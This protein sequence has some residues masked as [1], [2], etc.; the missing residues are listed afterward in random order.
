MA[1]EQL[2]D[3]RVALQ[4]SP[5]IVDLISGDDAVLARPEYR[6][7]TADT[8][9]MALQ[10]LLNNPI[11]DDQQKGYLLTNSWRINYRDK[12]PTAANFISEKY[13]G[14][15]ALHTYD[16]IRDVFIEF[17]DPTKPYRNLILYPH[18]SWGKAHLNS[19]RVRSYEGG[20]I[21]IGAIKVGDKICTTSGELQTVLQVHPQG[22]VPVYKVTFSDGRTTYATENHLWKAAKTYNMRK[23]S[24]SLKKYTKMDFVEP[25][26]KTVETK[27]IYTS[28]QQNPKARW[29]VPLTKPA[30]HKEIFH[31]IDPY[32]LGALLGDGYLSK[33]AV[34]LVG[35]DYEIH[36][37]CIHNALRENQK[38]AESSTK[39]V[40]FSTL[41]HMGR[42]SGPFHP[43]LTRLKLIDCLSQDKH[44]PEEYLYDSID[45]RIA[46]L[47]GL[48]D[49]DGTVNR[50]GNRGHLQ[51][52]TTSEALKDNFLTLVRG[53]GG[54][55]RVW[56]DNRYLKKNAVAKRPGY[57]VYFTFPENDFP[58]FRL[59]R[60][61]AIVDKDF[62]SFRVQRKPQNLK[63][64]SIAYEGV[65]EATCISVSDPSMLY[66]IDDYIV[67]HNS[68][69]STLINIY[70]GI[71]LSM[72]RNPYKFFGL[73]PA[74]ILSQLLV[75]YS[76]K[77]SS[78]LLLEPLIAILEASPFFE[79]VHTRESM[80]KKDHDYE[81]KTKIDYIYWTTAVPTSAIQ[82]SNGANFKLTSSPQSLLGLSVVSGTMS[83]LGFF[84]DAG[85][86]DEY[87]M[88][89]FN[90]LKSRIDSRMKGNY[91][92]RSILD[93]SPN[94]L[95]SPI[96]DYVVNHSRKDPTNY[97]VDGSVWKWSPDEYDM[98]KTFKVFLGG[99]G[100]PPRILETEAEIS[101]ISPNKM[102][103]VPMQLRQFFMDDLYK[104]LK[105]RAGIPAGSADSLIY[106]YTKLE[107]IFDTRLRNIYTHIHANSDEPA[108]R[109]IWNQ[110]SHLFFKSRAGKMEFWY[111][112]HIPRC[113]SVDQSI[114][115][116]VSC[117][118][119]GHNERIPASDDQMYVID[120]VVPIAPNGAR[121]GLDAIK[122]FIEDLSRQGGMTISHVSFDQF[123]SEASLQYLKSVGF[124][125]EK[126]S[127]DLTTDPYYHLLSLIDTRRI[128][129]G[130]NLYVKNNLKSLKIVKKGKS[131]KPTVDHEDSRPVITVGTEDWNKSLIGFYA[132]D[133][134]DA[135]AAVCDLLRRYHPVAY[136]AWDPSTLDSLVDNTAEKRAAQ[137]K[138]AN[139]MMLKG[140]KV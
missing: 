105:D 41:F 67:T 109:L 75:S 138:M 126:L 27:D 86:D 7:M 136:D 100:Q 85:K 45:N 83:E 113:V 120:F 64:D 129:L 89:I 34:T 16:R 17:M 119:V 40:N 59:C 28:M 92:G 23:W 58:V 110:I 135:I 78:E 4:L 55:A 47:Q 128:I 104:S 127:V 106:D 29:F 130:R 37:Y 124:E 101:V 140:I 44:I 118:A 68:Y 96:D 107:A 33:L 43:E 53:L 54:L 82:F 114:S 22:R 79:K 8:I 26:W 60:K 88:R 69:L 102:I 111:K 24:P 15:A 12:P 95:D 38:F 62:S 125:V 50:K 48:M 56:Q 20:G 81:R 49:T 21:P 1:E 97:V 93:S 115:Q 61:Q 80:V 57:V 46:L 42:Q 103:D 70:I 94:T 117:I 132:K 32:T 139:F 25:C 13:L 39:S 10:H 133:S 31:I 137:D 2:L 84:R 87:I 90:D 19:C 3:P 122:F 51:F 74:T 5:M 63:I 9:Q 98:T 73:N 30:Q 52:Y 123:Q 76:L 35:D 108:P 14:R 36:Q 99:K 91:F 66:L 11:L 71:H 121:I 134:T 77:K 65:E 72:M 6:T 112:P 116:D 131:K 18:I